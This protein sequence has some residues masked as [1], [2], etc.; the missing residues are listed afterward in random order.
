MS[1][2]IV[3]TI[4]RRAV[5]ESDFR[6]MLISDPNTALAAYDLTSE[7]RERLVKLDSSVF[8]G[9]QVD[10]EQRISRAKYAGN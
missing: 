3:Q 1:A 10:L 5:S 7:E 4:I 8:D 2:N 6:A 9:N